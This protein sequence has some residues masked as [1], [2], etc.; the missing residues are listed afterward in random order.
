M[1][2]QGQS[3]KRSTVSFSSPRRYSHEDTLS[4]GVPDAEVASSLR[5]GVDHLKQSL[6]NGD[7]SNA[8]QTPHLSALCRASLPA[9][10]WHTCVP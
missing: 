7:S 9:L 10:L 6:E 8:G 2:L 4:M 1:L 3:R 5:T